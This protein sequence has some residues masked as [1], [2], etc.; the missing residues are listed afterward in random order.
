MDLH[1]PRLHLQV[2]LKLTLE[3]WYYNETFAFI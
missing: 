1:E 2:S 3:I